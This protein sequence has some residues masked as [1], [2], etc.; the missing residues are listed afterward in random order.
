M[1]DPYRSGCQSQR[2]RG[3]I[4]NQNPFSRKALDQPAQGAYESSVARVRCLCLRCLGNPHPGSSG[5]QPSAHGIP[6]GFPGSFQRLRVGG[7]NHPKL[8]PARLTD[9]V[10]QGV[11]VA[12]FQPAVEQKGINTQRLQV[13]Q[14]LGNA[15]QI[16]PA[17]PIGVLVPGR[18][19]PVQDRT[20]PPGLRHDTRACPA[21]PREHLR[22]HRAAKETQARAETQ[23]ETQTNSDR[24]CPTNSQVPVPS[25]SRMSTY[26]PR[27][28]R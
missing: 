22:L 17:I 10:A 24:T 2:H 12:G 7:H 11:H 26:I 3:R 25:C 14:P 4:G 18:V 6:H 9:Q 23:A 16:T 20:P 27:K 21:W 13:I 15:P 28:P 8:M 1:T 19:D 5:I